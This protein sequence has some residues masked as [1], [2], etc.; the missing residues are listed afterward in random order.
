MISARSH[1]PPTLL[2]VV[3]VVGAIMPRSRSLHLFADSQHHPHRLF[4]A[5]LVAPKMSTGFCDA[6]AVVEES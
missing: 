6:T 5:F 4:K 3:G 1:D 2:V